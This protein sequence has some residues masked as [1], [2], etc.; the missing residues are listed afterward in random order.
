MAARDETMSET[1]NAEFLTA[2]GTRAKSDA[3]R[4]K[5]YQE[6]RSAIVN[7]SFGAGGRV[8]TERA[9]AEQFG[10]ARNTIRKTMNQL[11]REGLIE[12]HVGRGSF[13]A[14]GAVSAGSAPSQEFSLAELLEARLLFEPNIPD[15]VVER[16]TDDDIAVLETYLAEMLAAKTWDEFKEAKYCLHL[17]VVRAAHNPFMTF[18]F[19]QIVA[20]RRRAKWGRPGGHP[21]P[22]AA[23]REVAYRDNARIVDALK[24]G[25]AEVARQAIHDY[26]LNTL[27]AAS[28]S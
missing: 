24:S 18:V 10:T 1:T 27:S 7:G 17:A 8:P 19:E 20:S 4:Q 15:L 11:V 16:A 25:D 3:E 21:A 13:V 5:I 12:R 23:V 2:L 14:D 28:S 9:L 26:L 6:I 22:V